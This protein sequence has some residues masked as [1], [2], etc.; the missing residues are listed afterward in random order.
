[1]EVGWS[2]KGATLHNVTVALCVAP[3]MHSFLSIGERCENAIS[4]FILLDL[5][6][7]VADAKALSLQVG[8]GTTWMAGQT[9]HNLQGVAISTIAICLEKSASW[10]PWKNGFARLSEIS[11]EEHFGFLRSQVANAVLSTRG[12]FLADCRQSHKTNK[13]LN[14]SSSKLVP[15]EGLEPALTNEQLLGSPR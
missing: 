12:F 3:S 13:I 15:E 9:M 10:L 6:K 4:G 5:W 2:L 11:I 14:S 1:M 7:V 8:K